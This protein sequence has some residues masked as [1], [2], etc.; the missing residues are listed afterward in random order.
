MHQL[1]S[2][3]GGHWANTSCS[4]V[5]GDLAHCYLNKEE[6]N[7]NQSKCDSFVKRVAKNNSWNNGKD[8]ATNYSQMTVP[9]SA[10]WTK[11]PFRH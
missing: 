5:L 6:C 3:I 9:G 11:K 8:I 2:V 4:I 1:L 7:L 10:G